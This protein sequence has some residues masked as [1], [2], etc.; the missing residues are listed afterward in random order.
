MFVKENSITF[1]TITKLCNVQKD[2]KS[3]NFVFKL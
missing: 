3:N 2:S 1:V